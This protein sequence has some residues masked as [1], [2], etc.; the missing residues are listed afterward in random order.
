MVEVSSM[1]KECF[2]ILPWLNQTGVLLYYSGP[3]F[4][5]SSLSC[6]LS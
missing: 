3:Y 1:L 2:V 4:Q 6:A 5:D